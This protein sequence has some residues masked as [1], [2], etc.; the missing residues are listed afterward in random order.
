MN[1]TFSLALAAA[2]AASACEG[3]AP[4]GTPLA[5]PQ[6]GA[7]T[8]KDKGNGIELQVKGDGKAQL[9][10]GNSLLTFYVHVKQHAGGDAQGTFHQ[11]YSSGGLTSDFTGEVTCIAVDQANHRAWI[12]GVITK[13]RS[14]DPSQ[15]GGIFEPGSE[16]WFRVLDSESDPSGAPDRTTVFG[17]TG[18]GGLTTSAQYCAAQHWTANNANTWAVTR[19]EIRIQPE[20]RSL[21]R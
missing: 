21:A 4:T 12:G 16:I 9:P 18:S 10:P 11:R 5:S 20:E 19:G 13:N 14:T 6:S 2:L 7:F 15:Q 17:F 3:P 1:R 8:D